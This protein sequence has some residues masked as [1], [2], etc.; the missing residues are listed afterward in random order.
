MLRNVCCVCVCLFIPVTHSKKNMKYLPKKYISPASFLPAS[1]FTAL[2]QQKTGPSFVNKSSS[3]FL[4]TGS[5]DNNKTKKKSKQRGKETWATRLMQM[6]PSEQHGATP[7]L[8]TQVW[9]CGGQSALGRLRWP[10][11]TFPQLPLN[12]GFILPDQNDF[13]MLFPDL[14]S[15]FCPKNVNITELLFNPNKL[16]WK[17]IGRGLVRGFWSPSGVQGCHFSFHQES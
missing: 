14:V 9:I 4:K 3:V 1:S 17:H 5:E 16:F 10:R 6:V 13:Q 12:L 11:L 8:W 7:W 2:H 15:S